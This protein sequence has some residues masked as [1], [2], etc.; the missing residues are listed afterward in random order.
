MKLKNWMVYGIGV[1]LFII[2]VIVLIVVFARRD[3]V[4][5]PQRPEQARDVSHLEKAKESGSSATFTTRGEV[6]DEERHRMIEISISATE[7]K[8]EVLSGYDQQVLKSQTYPNTQAAY[9]AFLD[10]LNG[11]KFTDGKPQREKLSEKAACPLGLHYEY[12][13]TSPSS[14]EHR[15]WAT[16]CSRA[17]G[18]FNGNGSMVRTLFQNQIPDYGKIVDDVRLNY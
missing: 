9:E 13:V 10:A 14:E 1:V 3:N 4:P 12:K 2:I 17:D 6:V 18:T 11:A 5:D 15:L 7:R 16:S 8:V